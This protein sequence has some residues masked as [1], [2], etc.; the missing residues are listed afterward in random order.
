MK[1][2][3]APPRLLIQRSVRFR[4]PGCQQ[5]LLRDFPFAYGI[6]TGSERFE[7]ELSTGLSLPVD[8]LQRN[9]KYLSTGYP[10]A[11][12]TFRDM[13]WLSLSMPQAH[14]SARRR[15]HDR[16]SCQGQTVAVV[17]TAEKLREAGCRS[18]LWCDGVCTTGSAIISSFPSIRSAIRTQYFTLL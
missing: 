5:W 15:M 13:Y 17:R 7:K 14:S 10:C 18:V 12:I 9:L 8:K 2:Q 1:R 3:K 16:S 6:L 4:V 11:G